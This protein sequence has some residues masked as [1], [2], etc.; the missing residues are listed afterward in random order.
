MVREELALDSAE[1][2]TSERMADEPSTRTK[3]ER[4]IELNI[5]AALPSQ[6]FVCKSETRFLGSAKE[7]GNGRAFG[8]LPMFRRGN[9]TLHSF[10]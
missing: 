9:A 2:G 5:D 7:L 6:G 10:R 8:E 3:R 1:R 4:R